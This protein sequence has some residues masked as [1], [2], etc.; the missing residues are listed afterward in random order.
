[1][2]LIFDT[3][4][5]LEPRGETELSA[6]L[7][8]VAEKVRRRA[9]VM[10]FSDCFCDL[11]PLLNAFQ[12]LRFQKHDV[13]VFQL[14]DR[15]EPN[16]KF[17][18]PVRFVD[19]ESSLSLVTE[20]SRVRDEYLRQPGSFSIIYARAA[21]NSEWITDAWSQA[22]SY[23]RVLADF[24]VERAQIAAAVKRYADISPTMGAAG[25]ARSRCRHHPPAQPAFGI[26]PSSGLRCD[27]WFQPRSV[28]QAKLKQFLIVCRVLAVAMLVLFLARPLAG[29]WLGWALSP[30][31]D[32]CLFCST[33]LL[34][35]TPSTEEFQNASRRSI[36]AGS[37]TI[38]ANEP[39]C[40]DRQRDANGAGSRAGGFAD[41]PFGRR[42]ERYGC[43]FARDA[44]GGVRLAD[45]ESRGKRE[46]W[47]A[48]DNQQEQ[49]DAGGPR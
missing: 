46:I 47:I 48:S 8:E 30:A 22:Q 26:G 6:C 5:K 41:E 9:M 13:A 15:L 32:S 23:E 27:F 25:P 14:L 28:N 35:W 20:P 38:R 21:I 34:A 24:L 40:F 43:G 45:R 18:R 29:G 39:S 1:M 16:F 4:D 44:S 3:L 42:P 7:H 33:G 11:E 12:H 19:L 37:K 17:D 31:P 36:C 10:V 49:L 2:K